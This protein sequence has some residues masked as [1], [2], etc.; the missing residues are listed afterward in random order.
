MKFVDISPCNLNFCSSMQR[1]NLL[2]LRLGVI[3]WMDKTSPLKE[4]L[5]EVLTEA[6]RR[7]LE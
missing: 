1:S 4:L 3:E 7:V 5:A 2:L 6:E